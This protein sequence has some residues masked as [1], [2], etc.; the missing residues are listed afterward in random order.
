MPSLPGHSTLREPKTRKVLT[1]PAAKRWERTAE[2]EAP[3]SPGKAWDR[4]TFLDEQFGTDHWSQVT[5]VKYQKQ[6]H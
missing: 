2:T 3:F 4:L 6:K 5:D 1:N